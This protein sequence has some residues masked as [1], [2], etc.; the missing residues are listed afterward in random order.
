MSDF[1]LTAEQLIEQVQQQLMIEN[2]KTLIGT[3]TPKCFNLC[4]MKPGTKLTS[5]EQDCL[6]ECAGIYKQSVALVSSLYL[7][8]LKQSAQ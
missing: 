6:E 2:F 3:I 7:N 1:D 4:V 5:T 8:R